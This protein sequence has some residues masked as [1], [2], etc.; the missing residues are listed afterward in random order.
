[1]SQLSLTFAGEDILEKVNGLHITGISRPASPPRTS[2]R[3][4]IPGKDYA[5]NFG[6]SKKRGYEIIVEVAI[7]PGTVVEGGEEVEETLRDRIKQLKDYLEYED[8]KALIFTDDS[9]EGGT[10]HMAQVIE[11]VQM[12]EDPSRQ[13]ARG[14]ITFLCSGM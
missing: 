1:M 4:E 5:Y 6:N 11:A 3:V 7:M 2:H 12:E 10:T 14:T 13:L 9:G 8:E